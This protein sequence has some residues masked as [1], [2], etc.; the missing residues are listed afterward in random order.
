MRAG[1][2][3]PASLL[4]RDLFSFDRRAGHFAA[5]QIR[6]FRSYPGKYIRVALEEGYFERVHSPPMQKPEQ[7]IFGIL[8]PTQSGLG[9]AALDVQCDAERPDRWNTRS[10]SVS[11]RGRWVV[12]PPCKLP[13]TDL[14]WPLIRLLGGERDAW[15][16]PQPREDPVFLR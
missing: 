4:L 13:V 3:G 16:Q 9:I 2:L 7:N 6:R 11:V 12:K 8:A 10:C 5:Y 14:G 15:G 1:R